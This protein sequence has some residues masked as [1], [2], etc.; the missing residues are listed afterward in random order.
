MGFS[1]LPVRLKPDT[2]TTA[3]ITSYPAGI[4]PYAVS[5]F[6][7]TFALAL[8][9]VLIVPAGARAQQFRVE[10]TTIAAIHAAITAKRRISSCV[11]MISAR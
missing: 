6:S 7:R 11:Q 5:A 2:T 9:A 3:G 4:T 10:E 8:V 1:P